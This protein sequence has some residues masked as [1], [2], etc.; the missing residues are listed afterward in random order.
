MQ[1]GRTA[2]LL[3]GL[4]ARESGDIAIFVGGPLY[5]SHEEREMGFRT[6]LRE[7]HDHLKILSVVKSNDD[8]QRCY[9]LTMD[10]FK[11]NP[12]LRGILNI[13]GG[14][15]GIERAILELKKV[16]EVFYVCFNLT[17]LTRQAL[18]S[19]VLN[20]VVHQDMGRA[21]EIALQSILT[22]HSSG[23]MPFYHVPVEIIMRENI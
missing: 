2:G 23:Q 3:M 15:R 10:L 7:E 21:A 19:G 14:N 8:P 5:R 6:V 4:L 13:G 20:A 9:E 16:H 22:R 18:I 1:A 11:S 17:P 12:K